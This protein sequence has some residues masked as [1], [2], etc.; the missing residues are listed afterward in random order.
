VIHAVSLS[1]GKD[2]TAMLLMMIEKNMPID[3]IIF[4]DTT[5]EYPEI[6]EHLEKLQE[7]IKPHKIE[8]VKLDWNYWFFEHDKSE[9]KWAGKYR[10]E[11]GYG[12]PH[13][14]QRWCTAIKTNAVQCLLAYGEYN[15]R[16]RRT[17]KKG[18]Y[19]HIIEY[20]GIA[21]DEKERVKDYGGK[22][23]VKYPLVEWGI[24][25]PEAL[26]YCY[27]KG[28]DWN[29]LYNHFT[30]MSC[31]CCPLQSI[32]ELRTL[33]KEFP[34]LWAELQDMDERTH[35]PFSHGRSVD[36]Y[37]KRFQKDEKL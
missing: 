18:E 33:R 20:H 17:I 1:G 16:E 9:S 14:K 23:N 37:E 30:R 19:D 8:T 34:K 27:D 29:G 22:R 21:F 36:Y 11:P 7:H 35:K 31:W 32:D 6:Y 2:S 15:P 4:V 12:W 3:R 28:F 13:W 25:E 10:Y 26:R 5:K 24:T